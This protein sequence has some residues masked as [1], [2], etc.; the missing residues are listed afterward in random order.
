ME[1]IKLKYWLVKLR[2]TL[3]GYEK[4]STQLIEA[5]DEDRAQERALENESYNDS[6]GYDGDGEW[7]DDAVTLRKYL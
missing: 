5:D 1:N 7:W 3:G 4:I 6:A 2:L